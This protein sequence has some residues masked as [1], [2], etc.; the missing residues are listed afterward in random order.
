MEFGVFDD[1][2]LLE[3]DRFGGVQ[4]GSEK[5]DGDLERVFGDGGGVS[6][7]TGECVPVSDEVETVEG[8]IGLQPDPVLEGAKIVA[9]VET[10]GGTH[11]GENALGGVSQT[12]ILGQSKAI[13]NKFSVLSK[14][15]QACAAPESLKLNTKRR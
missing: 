5:V 8:G 10:A 1:L 15:R 4:A 7:I 13:S 14:E 9:D 3:D 2:G 11:A 12:V 6:V